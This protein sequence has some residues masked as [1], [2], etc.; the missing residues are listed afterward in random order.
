[1]ALL[2]IVLV[3]FNV[4]TVVSAIAPVATEIA[5]DIRLGSIELGAIGTMPP[6]A[7][8]A[9]ALFGAAIARR[10]GVERLL[11]LAIVAMVLG[12]VLR[13]VAPSFWVLLVGTVV[14]L[15]GAGVGNVL[16]PPLVKRYFPDRIALVTAVYVGVVSMSAAVPAA[17]ASPVTDAAGWRASLGVWA[18]AAFVCLLPWLVILV[19]DRRARAAVPDA[20]TVVAPRLPSGIWRSKV[21]WAVALIFSLSSAHVY[22]A[23]AWLPLLLVEKAG[24]SQAE[25]GAM[26]GAYALVGLPAALIVPPLATRL[27]SVA[28]VLYAGVLFFIVGYGGLL[29]MPAE[30]PWVWVIAAGAGTITFPLALTLINL[31]TRTQSGSVALSGFVQG[32]GYTIAAL[33]PFLFA[34]LYDASGGWDLPLYYLLATALATAVVG[35]QLGRPLMLEDELEAMARRG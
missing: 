23:F 30:A 25:A 2:G 1:M 12:H 27:R 3:A 35:R 22:S 33:G 6:I 11:A 15:A 19:R 29:F 7:F 8:A 20:V 16:L 26:L 18:V 21:A 13:S 24:V 34:L 17:V 4:R 5:Q 9:A 10:V 32:V 31:R 28:V 14:A